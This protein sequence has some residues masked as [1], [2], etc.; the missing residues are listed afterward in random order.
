MGLLCDYAVVLLHE[1]NDLFH[2][3]S[4]VDV[5][6]LWLSSVKACCRKT[7]CLCRLLKERGGGAVVISHD[8]S[9][10]MMHMDRYTVADGGI[11]HE[12]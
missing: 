10:D 11:V 12:R 8:M 1:R 2:E 5:A 9:F 6:V 4:Y 3:A 7:E